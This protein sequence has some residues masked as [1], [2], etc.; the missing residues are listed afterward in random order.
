M[1]LPKG[2]LFDFDGVIVDSKESHNSAWASAFKELFNS[3][4]APF[5]K[6][7]AGK[8]PMIIAEYFCSVIGQEERT[9]ELFYLKDIH[10]DKYFKVPKLLPGVRE[11]TTFLSEKNISY[12]IA[13]NATK[14]FLKNSIHYLN[15]EFTTVFGVQDYIKPK[16]A[17]EAYITLAKALNFKETDFK[18]I[19]VFEDSL[20]GTRAAKL[21]GMIPIGISTQ[22][23][24]EELKKAGSILVFPTL[25]EAYHFLTNKF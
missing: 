14:Q 5:P 2:F 21:A 3:E 1:K 7:H 17:P 6:T 16:P 18:D 23:S 22:Y 15:L 20:T 12:G 13:S 10:L 9:E 25:L 24:E 11:F 8:S 19:W 4:I